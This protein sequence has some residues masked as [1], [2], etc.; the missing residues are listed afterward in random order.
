MNKFIKR[1]IK[2]NRYNLLD[3]KRKLQIIKIIR[4]WDALIIKKWNK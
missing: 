4:G 1:N 3:Q 2:S